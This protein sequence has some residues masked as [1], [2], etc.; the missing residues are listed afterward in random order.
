MGL[1][2]TQLLRRAEGDQLAACLAA[3]G[4]QLDQPVAGADHIE[5]VL[6]QDDGVARIQ[7]LGKGAHQL[8]DVVEV[9]AGGGL[10]EHEERALARELL[11]R[12]AGLLRGLDQVAGQLQALRLTAGQ[13]RHRLTQLHIVQ[14]HIGQRLQRAHHVHVLRE[15]THRFGH[16]QLQHV[17]DAELL[18]EPLDGDLTHLGAKARAIAVRATQVHVRQELHLDVLKPGAPA[19]GAAPRARV[20]AEG[21]GGVL[22]LARQRRHGKQGAHGVEGT[23]IAGRVGAGR[24]ADGRLIDKVDRAQ[25]VGTQQLVVLAG[26]VG[27]QAEVAQQ[28]GVQDVLDQRRF[29]RSAH[30]G[31]AHQALQRER[32][33][34]VLQVVLT[35]ALQDQARRV[36]GHRAAQAQADGA[37]R[38]QVGTGQGLGVP[39]LIG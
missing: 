23:H 24:L 8:G 26:R 19:G 14:P 15:Q 31:H 34:Q 27:G 11:A 2:Q 25:P 33:V 32:D 4:A 5:V 22:A 17:G 6:D 1:A 7:Q 28:R 16:G 10:V 21:A 13:R 9:Q 29:A 18:V 20:E 36:F 35:R 37:A 3:L 38:T 39:E 30:P 12:L